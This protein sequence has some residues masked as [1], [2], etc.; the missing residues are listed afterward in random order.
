MTRVT[1]GRAWLPHTI[2][3]VLWAE[4]CARPSFQA[5]AGLRSAYAALWIF[6][7]RVYFLRGHRS[8]CYQLYT[9]V[10]DNG[11]GTGLDVE[12]GAVGLGGLQ[13]GFLGG[14]AR[15]YQ[16]AQQGMDES[17]QQAQ[18]PQSGFQPFGG[19]GQRLGG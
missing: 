8:L 17:A 16:P 7:C 13:G 1:H 11:L 18:A 2:R 12:M 19:S 5:C 4:L 15:Q 10:R 9:I 14:S 6:S 3:N